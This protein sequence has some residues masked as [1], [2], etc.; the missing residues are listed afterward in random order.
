MKIHTDT[1]TLR[2]HPSPILFASHIMEN[3]LLSD[4]FIFFAISQLQSLAFCLSPSVCCLSVFAVV[5]W[6]RCWIRKQTGAPEASILVKSHLQMSPVLYVA[7]SSLSLLLY[8]GVCFESAQLADLQKKSAPCCIPK[9]TGQSRNPYR[10][11]LY[12][13]LSLP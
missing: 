12:F 10:K 8:R 4:S 7:G 9:Y 11:H 2:S 6:L 3:W 5:T 1:Q 13:T